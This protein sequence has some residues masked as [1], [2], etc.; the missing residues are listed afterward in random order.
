LERCPLVHGDLTLHS[1]DN[2]D[3]PP[4]GENLT[5][6]SSTTALDYT[7]PFSHLHFVDSTTADEVPS[8]ATIGRLQ[9]RFAIT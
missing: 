1:P 2:H 7:A 6:L 3:I 4:D 9:P 8:L 5:T